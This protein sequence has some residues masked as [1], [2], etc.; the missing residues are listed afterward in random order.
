MPTC[1][2]I[3][4]H[5]LNA[6][7]GLAAEGAL[8]KRHL[9]SRCGAA[10]VVSS[11]TTRW[12]EDWALEG[13]HRVGLDYSPPVGLQESFGRQPPLPRTLPNLRVLHNPV[14]SWVMPLLGPTID[15][16]GSEATRRTECSRASQQ[17]PLAGLRQHFRRLINATDEG[18]WRHAS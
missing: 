3:H 5:P 6:D 2:W 18:E 7:D 11:I 15:G 10:A 8:L 9:M 16:S 13:T 1:R 4:E 17:W 14:P 12:W